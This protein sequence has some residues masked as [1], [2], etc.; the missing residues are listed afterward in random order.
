MEGLPGKYSDLHGGELFAILQV[1]SRSTAGDDKSKMGDVC[2]LREL[3][4]P[5]EAIGC[6]AF[7]KHDEE[8]AEMKRMFVTDKCRGMGLG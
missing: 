5:D 1:P 8:T 6:I 7:R 2:E 3:S 4:L